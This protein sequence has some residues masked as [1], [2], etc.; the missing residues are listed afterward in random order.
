[1]VWEA[2]PADLN[3]FPDRSCERTDKTSLG[4]LPVTGLLSENPQKSSTPTQSVR[5][6][7]RLPATKPALG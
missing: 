4:Y 5:E 3:R 7:I 6:A 1:M 2:M